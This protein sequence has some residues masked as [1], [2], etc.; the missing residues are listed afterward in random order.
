M[1]GNPEFCSVEFVF[2]P[3]VQFAA[4]AVNEALLL[5]GK[6][7]EGQIFVGLPIKEKI[8]LPVYISGNFA[9][10]PGRN[11]LHRESAWN[12]QIFSGVGLAAYLEVMKFIKAE[13]ETEYT[14]RRNAWLEFGTSDMG[15]MFKFGE[16]FRKLF[17]KLL[18]E[19]NI[20]YPLF[21][22]FYENLNYEF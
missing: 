9:L 15:E 1:G 21:N 18:Q 6:E 13:K 7:A 11:N 17:P 2:P 16:N 8:E 20:A 4:V 19:P 14:N 10:D 5:E 3:N 12:D 22:Q